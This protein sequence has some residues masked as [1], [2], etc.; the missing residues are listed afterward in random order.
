MWLGQCTEEEI[1]NKARNLL[2]DI[3]PADALVVLDQFVSGNLEN[4][5]NKSAYLCS[6]VR[7]VKTGGTLR[8]QSNQEVA[9]RERREQREYRDARGGEQRA[10]SILSRGAQRELDGMVRKGLLK[11]G[12]LDQRSLLSLSHLPGTVTL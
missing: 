11:L 12:D 4:V 2:A 5:R 10:D 1:D 3:A 8:N 6:L 9:K 7:V